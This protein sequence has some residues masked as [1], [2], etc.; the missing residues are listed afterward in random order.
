MFT[1]IDPNGRENH[2]PFQHKWH[3]NARWSQLSVGTQLLHFRPG[4]QCPETVLKNHL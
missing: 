4:H 1:V 3:S 2:R